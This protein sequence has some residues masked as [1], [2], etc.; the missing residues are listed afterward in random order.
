MALESSFPGLQVWF[1]ARPDRSSE[2]GATKSQ[3]PGSPG[4]KCHSSAS[5]AEWHREYYREDGGDTSRVRAVVCH[6]NPS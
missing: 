5:A 6:V 1:R 2:R 3:S 4:K